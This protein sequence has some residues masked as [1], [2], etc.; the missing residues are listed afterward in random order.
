MTIVMETGLIHPPV[1]LNI[2]VIKNIAPDIALSDI[3]WGVMPFV[4]LML[5]A[6]LLICIYPG[7]ATG[8]PDWVMGPIAT[9]RG[10]H[11]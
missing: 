4:V 10:Q 1:G 6:V 2:F 11:L 5:L 3:I 7:I 9:P 8:L